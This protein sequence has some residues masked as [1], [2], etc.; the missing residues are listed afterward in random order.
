[1]S[2]VISVFQQLAGIIDAQLKQYGIRFA[3]TK[4]DTKAGD[5]EV[6]IIFTMTFQDNALKQAFI[7]KIKQG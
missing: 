2:E 6:N 4:I 1:M 5:K 3:L 7:N